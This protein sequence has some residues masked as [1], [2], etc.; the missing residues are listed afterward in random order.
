MKFSM[1]FFNDGPL[2][3]SIKNAEE[4]AIGMYFSH[5]FKESM[6][7]LAQIEQEYAKLLKTNDIEAITQKK[8]EIDFYENVILLASSASNKDNKITYD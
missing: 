8:K 2:N 5:C 6:D 3:D 7:Y 4:F 1:E